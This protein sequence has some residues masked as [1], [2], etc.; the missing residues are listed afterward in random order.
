MRFIFPTSRA[1]QRGTN[2]HARIGIK[3]DDIFDASRKRRRLP[4]N[5]QKCRVRGSAQQA[6]EF[7]QLTALSLPADPFPSPSGSRS[8][9]D[10]QKR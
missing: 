9:C 7:V 8:A 3:R 4:A 5:G 2:G 6:I 10:V 1:M